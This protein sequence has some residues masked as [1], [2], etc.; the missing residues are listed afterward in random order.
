MATKLGSAYIDISANTAQLQAGLIGVQGKFKGALKSALSMERVMNRLAFIGTVGLMYTLGRAIQTAFKDGTKDAIEFESAIAHINT[1]L[2]DGAK[3]YLPKFKK[4]IE[5][6]STGLGKDVKDLSA[7][8]YDIISARIPP[9][10]ALYVLQQA[11]ELATANQAELRTVTQS[12]LTILKAYNMEVSDAGR[13]T[14]QLQTA[15]KFGRM[16]MSELAPVLGD[17]T[18]AAAILNIR[19]EDVLGSLATMT[20]AGFNPKKAVTS[21]R[22]AFMA[23]SENAEL[24]AKIQKDGFLSVL[25]II[26]AMGTKQQKIITGG[27]RGFQTYAVAMQNWV[28]A[29]QDVKE[30]MKSEEAVAKALGIEM[31]TT[32]ADINKALQKNKKEWRETGDELKR[33]K[34]AFIEMGTAVAGFF[35]LFG[36]DRIKEALKQMGREFFLFDKGWEK[37]T[38]YEGAWRSMR[39]TVAEANNDISS[40][41]GTQIQEIEALIETEEKRKQLAQESGESGKKEISNLINLYKELIRLNQKRADMGF[42]EFTNELLDAQIASAELK[43]ELV[44][45]G[46][47]SDKGLRKI[48][49]RIRAITKDI[50]KLI[51]TPSAS[52][53]VSRINSETKTVADELEEILEKIDDRIEYT[54]DLMTD[55]F[56]NAFDII[57]D[58]TM[59]GG[60]KL[61]AIWENLV[62]SLISEL[63]R[64]IAK[65]I[66]TFLISK[67]L[68]LPFLGG[69][70]SGGTPTG[71]I[72]AGFSG[73]SLPNSSIGG[74]NSSPIINNNMSF[75]RRD[76]GWIVNEGQNYNNNTRL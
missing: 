15:I 61:N 20:R 31:N 60:K 65:M 2:D 49:D 63:N 70:V 9:E 75:S 23:M 38:K 76:M 19:L 4:G 48:N 54:T 30:M 69:G 50:N 58:R 1:V 29:G 8:L 27:I 40:G 44:D 41:L 67:L 52:K 37:V 46:K 32:Q 51:D 73:I 33:Y 47:E 3:Q 74:G 66:A 22:R 26:E 55:R 10:H 42:T 13:I 17:V 7:S 43:S 25:P 16:E 45:M 36:T 6:I 11:T 18:S 72:D 53:F 68:N 21:M 62:D 12:V 64:L 39:K 5:D 14:D 24:S 56:A 57:T 34:L 28:D 71:I 59:E 35:A